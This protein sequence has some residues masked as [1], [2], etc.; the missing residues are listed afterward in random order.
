MGDIIFLKTLREFPRDEDGQIILEAGQK[1]IDRD[2]GKMWII[3]EIEEDQVDDELLLT[4]YL[5]DLQGSPYKGRHTEDYFREWFDE[6]GEYWSWR[7]E[8]IYGGNKPRKKG[9]I[10]IQGGKKA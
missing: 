3:S 10:V 6:A 2:T 9:L 7:L 8:T 1:W 4:I 5:I